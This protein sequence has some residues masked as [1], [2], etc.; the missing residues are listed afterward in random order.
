MPDPISQAGGVSEPSEYA[1]LAMDRRVTGL[2]TQRSPI[3]DADVPYLVGKYYGGSRYDSLL[4]GVNREVTARLTS[5]RRP[6][7]S[8]YNTPSLPA[9]SFYSYKY[10]QDGT[11]VIRVMEDTAYAIF[12]ATQGTAPKN[13]YT[14]D[15]QGKKARFCGVNTE[16]FW[17]DGDDSKKWI[18]GGK[19]WAA[20]KTFT[21][22][23]LITDPNGNVQVFESQATTLT[24]AAIEI[25]TRNLPPVFGQ[26]FLIV[27]FTADVPP[28][29][30]L[31]P[32]TFAGL[33]GYVA[34]NGKIGRAHV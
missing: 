11:E 26:T 24:I 18:N 4:D 8:I 25:V 22:G 1:A 30:A 29:P 34:L 12:D 15:G 20:N 23:D 7:S 31:Q 32:F 6:G 10:I 17:T 9:Y 16:L 14:K 2:W 27:T 19:A 21:R 13:I 33:T 28:I 5:A 3:R